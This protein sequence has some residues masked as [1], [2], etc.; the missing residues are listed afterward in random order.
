MPENKKF[1]IVVGVLDNKNSSNIWMAT[2]FLRFGYSVIPINYRT[3]IPVFGMRYF[4]DLLLNAIEHYSPFL[5]VFCKCNGIDPLIVKACTEKVK[6]WLYFMDSYEICK[7]NPEIVEHAKNSSFSSC[8]SRITVDYFKDR[9][10]KNC[11][12]I[13][14][15][16]ETSLHHPVTPVEKYKAD[17]SFIGSRTKERDEYKELLESTKYD[18]KFYGNGYSEP[19]GVEDWSSVCS[20]SKFMLSL[21]SFNNIPGYFSGR[22]FEYLGC[23]VCTFHLDNTGTLDEYIEDGKEIIYFKDKEDLLE[24]LST[25]TDEE[26]GKIALAGRERVYKDYTFNHSVAQILKIAGLK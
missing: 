21:N 14:E 10:V 7:R 9:G 26:A 20:S 5:I 15:G 8:T 12:H 23:G 2:S 22:L 25:T 6:T 24:K 3:I 17:I 11:F 13:F 19:L 16:I 1:V 18:V 4:S